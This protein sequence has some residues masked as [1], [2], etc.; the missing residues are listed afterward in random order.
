MMKT[1]AAASLAIFT[2]MTFG[3]AAVAQ[4]DSDAGPDAYQTIER[5]DRVF[6][7]PRQVIQHY[8]RPLGFSQPAERSVRNDSGN[9]V[10]TFSVE[11]L[12]DDSITE[13]EWRVVLNQT[14]RGMRPISAGTRYRCARGENA[15]E[16]STTPCP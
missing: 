2:M 1:L 14:D 13:Q 8:I 10:V 16:W 11:G 7:G 6:A 4:D 9:R 12:E 5:P 15:G 3:G